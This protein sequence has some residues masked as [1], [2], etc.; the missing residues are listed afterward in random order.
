MWT[1]FRP[2][3]AAATALQLQSYEPYKPQR[4]YRDEAVFG[5]KGIREQQNKCL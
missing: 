3:L 5:E 4:F 2:Y 1:L